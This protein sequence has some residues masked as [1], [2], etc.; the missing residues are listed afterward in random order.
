MLCWNLRKYKMQSSLYNR[1][2]RSRG[3]KRYT[4]TLSLTSA[5]DGGGWL[6]PRPGHFTP[7]KNTWNPTYRGL[8]GPHVGWDGCGNPRLP[9]V[10][11]PRTVLPVASH[12]SSVNNSGHKTAK[13]TKWYDSNIRCHRRMERP[14]SADGDGLQ[15][16]RVAANILLK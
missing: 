3:K 9:P 13:R 15:V 4:F 8:G 1:P 6:R 12:E 2:E 5:L 10:F 16:W 14:R 7:G 11:D